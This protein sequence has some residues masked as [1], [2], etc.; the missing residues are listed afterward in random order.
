[1]EIG[2]GAF[3]GC[4]KL[5]S[6]KIPDKITSISGDMLLGCMS[7]TT[8]TIPEGVTQIGDGAFQDCTGLT[9]VTIPE[10]VTQI[11]SAAFWNC[12]RLTTVTIPESVTQIDSAAFHNCINLT[13]VT[14]PQNVTQ[15]GFATFQNCERLTTVTIPDGVTSI[16]GRAFYNCVTLSNV[17]I[18]D[19]VTSIGNS[20]FYN[21]TSLTSVTIP[22]SVTLIDD[23]A[24]AKCSK[25]AEVTVYCR[26]TKP[27][28]GNNV[29]HLT[30]ALENN[31]IK[32][33]GLFFI[34]VPRADTTE[35]VYNRSEQTYNIPENKNYTVKG[36]TQTN[37]DTYTVTVS[38]KDG[39][40]WEDGKT[41]DKTYTFKILPKPLKPSDFYIPVTEYKYTGSEIRPAVVPA[42]G[43]FLYT[44][45]FRVNYRNNINAGAATIIITG[46]NNYSGV[47]EHEFKIAPATIAESD[48]VVDTSDKVYTGG[49]IKPSVTSDNGLITSN[50]YNVTYS[51]N[52]NTGVA[53]IAAEGKNNFTGKVEYSFNIINA[54]QKAPDGFI[55][56][57][58]SYAKDADGQINGVNSNMEYRAEDETD[59][60]AINSNVLPGLTPGRYFIRYKARPN[61]N[62]S[63]DTEI[64]INAGDK[65]NTNVEI[66]AEL[67]KVYDG[68]PA[69][70][71]NGY[72]YYGDGTA[73]I[74]W[75]SDV[76]GTKG[77]EITAPVNAGTYWVG[78]LAEGTDRYNPASSY[79][80][81][82]I[83]QA[84]ITEANFTV[85][86]A[87]KVYTGEEIKSAVASDNSLITADDFE[88]TYTD[89]INAGI[90]EIKI[91]GKN[92]FKGTVNYKF[93]IIK[94]DKKLSAEGLSAIINGYA[95][96]NN[97]IITG[98]TPDM[99]YRKEGE[100]TYTP[101][102]GNEITDLENGTYYIRYAA[103]KNH[104]AS[105][106]VK[107]TIDAPDCECSCHS[108]DK[109]DCF[110]W[111]ISRFFYMIF[112]LNKECMCGISHY[113]YSLT[114]LINIE[115]DKIT[116]SINSVFND[117]FSR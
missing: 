47:V 99:E 17:T 8:V 7:L 4:T 92:N 51:E 54:E 73:E 30:P 100:T 41:E 35:F 9:T 27:K 114:D 32:Y 38:L 22:E 75:Y 108:D 89:N 21:C 93:E 106:D 87:K 70:F 59:Y 103:D 11:G 95:E 110:I 13:S 50:D 78:V 52:I 49:E 45:D 90:A 102:T 48:F 101:V 19:S 113:E 16:D 91:T 36:N 80:Q 112:S 111:K 34:P 76:E 85:D 83:S 105:E 64:I 79:K 84:I 88:V 109:L 15:I 71:T 61:Y 14:I 33:V 104:N 25:L 81:F 44:G 24:F 97:G 3:M 62:P 60:T 116:V 5:T 107:V 66:T 31:N 117:I 39:Y 63:D 10:S 115:L 23:E 94:A 57:H 56:L 72:I 29:F 82:T 96:N 18:P 98:V 77:S 43:T 46:V 20:A 74:K 12:S 68:N 28:S 6:I 37:A 40:T 65:R 26:E 67:D 42:L 53:T 1:M 86:T 2:Y 69:E 55:V 58:E